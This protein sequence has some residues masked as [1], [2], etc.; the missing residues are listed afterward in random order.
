MCLNSLQSGSPTGL[1][2]KINDLYRFHIRLT[3]QCKGRM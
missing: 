1:T 3:L 2:N